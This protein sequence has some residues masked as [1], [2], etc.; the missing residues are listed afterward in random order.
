LFY[1]DL[2]KQCLDKRT[3]ARHSLVNKQDCCNIST[4]SCK[5]LELLFRF[6][7]IK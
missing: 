3:T 4:I 5:S 2:L 1:R 7:S 6:D